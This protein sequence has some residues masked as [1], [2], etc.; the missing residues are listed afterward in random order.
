MP[1]VAE[2]YDRLHG[3]GDGRIRRDRVRPRLWIRR[4]DWFWVWRLDRLDRLGVLQ[5]GDA[6][7]EAVK[8]RLHVLQCSCGFVLE[9][10]EFVLRWYGCWQCNF[11]VDISTRL[12]H[13]EA[14]TRAHIMLT[15]PQMRWLEREAKRLDVS[16][17]EVIRRI[18]DQVRE[19]K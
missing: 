1:L 11:P 10:V 4:L 8:L 18:L 19:T 13:V 3:A 12:A 7:G 14:M 16:I 9:I 5:R 15:D 17:S 2:R 6:G